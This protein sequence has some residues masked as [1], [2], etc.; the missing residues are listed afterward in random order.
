MNHLGVDSSWWV[1]SNDL[2]HL[3]N[4]PKKK[5][6]EFQWLLEMFGAISRFPFVPRDVPQVLR[7]SINTSG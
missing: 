2:T 7:V 5:K 4:D 6:K 3:K 1:D